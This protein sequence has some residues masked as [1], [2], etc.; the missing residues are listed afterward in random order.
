MVADYRYNPTLNAIEVTTS[1]TADLP[2][3]SDMLRHI[4]EL[5]AQHGSAHLLINH[6]RL[7]AGLINMNDIRHLGRATAQM[8]EI[9][10]M[11]RFAHVVDRDLQYGLVRAWETLA[12]LN[13]LSAVDNRLF[14]NR[15]EAVA[16]LA[17]A[18]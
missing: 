12:G 3:L 8:R 4:A 13:G 17:T 16:W 1:G 9:F 2:G 5:C 15:S 11:R 7:D 18:S 10:G 14:R 6:S